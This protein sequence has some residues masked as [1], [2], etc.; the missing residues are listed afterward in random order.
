MKADSGGRVRMLGW[1]LS[2]PPRSSV[3]SW[4]LLAAACSASSGEAEPS[5]FR[6]LILAE[7]GDQHEGFVVAALEWLK[8]TATNE[9]FEYD[10]L[11]MPDGLP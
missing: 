6:A 8:V 1:P 3:A 9:H 10:V 2:R 11:E 7:R 4:S 5:R